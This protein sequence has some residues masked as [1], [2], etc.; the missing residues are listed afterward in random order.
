MRIR[1]NPKFIPG[2]ETLILN[3]ET[4]DLACQLGNAVQQLNAPNEL[5]CECQV[6]AVEVEHR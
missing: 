1:V 2:P 6:V 4:D 5:G 3:R